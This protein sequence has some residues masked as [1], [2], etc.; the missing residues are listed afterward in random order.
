[1]QIKLT[2][3]R[4]ML[5]IHVR[6]LSPKFFYS[7]LFTSSPFSFPKLKKTLSL[8]LSLSALHHRSTTAGNGFDEVAMSLSLSFYSLKLTFG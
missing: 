6:P 3:H 7:F 8:S 1:M 4:D 5:A 2:H